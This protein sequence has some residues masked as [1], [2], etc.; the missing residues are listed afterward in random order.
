MD[1]PGATIHTCMSYEACTAT[2]SARLSLL[3]HSAIIAIRLLSMASLRC[4]DTKAMSEFIIRR[5]SWDRRGEGPVTPLKRFSVLAAEHYE[6]PELPH[7]IFYAML[8]NEVE[9][10]GVPHG[11]RLRSVE[12]AL[13]KLHWGAFE[14]W[15]CLFGDQVYK[16]RFHQ[17]GGS[18]EGTRAGHQGESS[19]VGAAADDATPEVWHFLLPAV[20]ERWL[21]MLGRPSSSSSGSR[22]PRPLPEDSNVLCPHFSLAE[23][24]A[25]AAELELPEIAT[26]YTMLL[27]EMLELGIVHEYPAERMKSLL[28][29]L[30]WSTFEVWVRI[31]DEVI[32]GAQFHRQLDEVDVKGARD[33]QREGS[34][35]TDPPAPSSDEE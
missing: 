18:G 13:T 11:P 33:G 28:V 15:I 5:F 20:R 10:L 29:G 25:A 31:M 7:V 34:G 24:E 30:R 22:P 9:K 23:A 21:T 26:F 32:R 3:P 27:N 6:L 14:S 35:S 8:L 2:L 12:V 17:K 1:G 4:L 19:S 16:A